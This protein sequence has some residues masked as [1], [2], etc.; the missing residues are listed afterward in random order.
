M[1]EMITIHPENLAKAMRDGVLAYRDVLHPTM[2]K[3][4]LALPVTPRWQGQSSSTDSTPTNSPKQTC[5]NEEGSRSRKRAMVIESEMEALIHAK[6]WH[7][8]ANITT[9][10]AAYHALFNPESGGGSRQLAEKVVDQL[11][12]ENQQLERALPSDTDVFTFDQNSAIPKP[13]SEFVRLL[14]ES[15][16]VH[17]GGMTGPVQS[18]HPHYKLTGFDV[19]KGIMRGTVLKGVEL[20]VQRPGDPTTLRLTEFSLSF[21]VSRSCEFLQKFEPTLTA[22]VKKSFSFFWQSAGDKRGR[23]HDNA[24]TI[25]EIKLPERNPDAPLSYK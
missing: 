1:K 8:M 3:S 23:D 21:I 14:K 24:E 20:H 19:A 5:L 18:F 25:G 2:P 22:R 10:L 15:H 16:V 4:P 11:F 12:P 9:V 13:G 17:G 6:N 7:D